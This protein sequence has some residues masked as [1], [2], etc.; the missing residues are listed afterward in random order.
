MELQGKVGY[1]FFGELI[2]DCLER[3]EHAMSQEHAFKAGELCVN[4]QNEAVRIP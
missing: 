4:A 3:T 1:P 2:L